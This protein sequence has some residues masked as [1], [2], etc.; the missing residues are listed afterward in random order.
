MVIFGNLL[1]NACDACQSLPPNRR[2]IQIKASLP[3]PNV[4]VFA[5]DN[6]YSVPIQ[7][8]DNQYLS[9]KH[10]GFGTGI[11]SVQN[12]VQRYRGVLTLEEKDG[13]FCVSGMLNLNEN[14]YCGSCPP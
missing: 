11:D 3:N 5:I 8:V 6:T 1:E 13:M 7:K 12:I 9:S 14:A 4:L 2:K 10:S